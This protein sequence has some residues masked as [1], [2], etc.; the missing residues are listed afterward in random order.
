MWLYVGR[1]CLWWRGKDSDLTDDFLS[2][3]SRDEQ[4]G[5]PG[6]S[7]RRVGMPET[8]AWGNG[9]HQRVAPY[10]YKESRSVPFVMYRLSAYGGRHFGR[11]SRQGTRECRGGGG[12]RVDAAVTPAQA[13]LHY[14]GVGLVS[15]VAAQRPSDGD[16]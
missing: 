15:I 10:S 4:R 16:P 6:D 2:I 3:V 11:S 5:Y 12:A 1:L 9:K 14:N 7:D 8:V 13:A